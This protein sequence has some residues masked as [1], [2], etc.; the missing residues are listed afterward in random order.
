MDF[1]LYLHVSEGVPVCKKYEILDQPS[2]IGIVFGVYW[3]WI[4]EFGDLKSDTPILW[5]SIW[6]NTIISNPIFFFPPRFHRIWVPNTMESRTIVSNTM[7]SRT[8]VSNTME[9]RTI[10]F[11]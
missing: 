11:A 8:I 6:P 10:V 1:D 9:S 3:N 4:W 7:E 5:G 2:F